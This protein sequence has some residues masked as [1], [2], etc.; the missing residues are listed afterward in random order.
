MKTQITLFIVAI[1]FLA[2]PA[3]A[4]NAAAVFAKV[5]PSVV[6]VKGKTA[7]GSGVAVSVKTEGFSRVTTIVTNCHVVIDETVVAITHQSKTGYAI[8][9]SC[10]KERDLA[11]LEL[12]GELPVVTTRPSASLKVGEPVYAVGAPRGLDLSISDGIVSQLR[13]DGIANR[14]MPMIQT[15]AAIS[16]GSSG[17]GLFDAQGRLVGVTTLYLKDSQSLNFAMPSDW[18]TQASARGNTNSVQK[19]E[20]VQQ[21]QKETLASAWVK[22]DEGASGNVIYIDYSTVKQQGGYRFAWVLSD[23]RETKR[24]SN[25]TTYQSTIT[26]MAFD[27]SGERSV[28]VSLAQYSNQLGTGELVFSQSRQENELKF[29][30]NIPGTMGA[31]LLQEVC[32]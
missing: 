14:A 32:K 2:T 21:Q 26:R 10:D 11:L 7:Q 20:I 18:I 27:C 30:D 22:V 13:G 6:V 16:P 19:T 12:T 24:R 23:F 25:N 28:I 17:G 15:T 1:L 3:S 4:Q 9:K 29:N 8:V 5:S 31:K